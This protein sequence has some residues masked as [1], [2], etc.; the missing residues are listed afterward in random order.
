MGVAGGGNVHS[1]KVLQT[2]PSNTQELSAA[3]NNV[4]DD[5]SRANLAGTTYIN[6]ME[7][8]TLVNGNMYINGTLGY[9]SNASATTSV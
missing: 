4:G 1:Y 9:T 6:R 7:G 8:N 2:L 3:L 5:T